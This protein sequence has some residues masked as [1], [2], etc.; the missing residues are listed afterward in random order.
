MN[1]GSFSGEN[2]SDIFQNDLNKCSLSLY[3]K[4]MRNVDP[5]FPKESFFQSSKMDKIRWNTY[6]YFL[7]FSIEVHRTLQKP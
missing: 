2:F 4:T 3:E 7:Y 5:V 6:S 1:S